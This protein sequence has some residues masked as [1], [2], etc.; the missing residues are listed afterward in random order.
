M[1]N[2]TF[3]FGPITEI[4][5]AIAGRHIVYYRIV[6]YTHY[7]NVGRYKKICPTLSVLTFTCF[8]FLARP[9]TIMYAVCTVPHNASILFIYFFF[10]IHYVYVHDVY[11]LKSVPNKRPINYLR[12][13]W[14][15][16]PLTICT[17][18]FNKCVC[19]FF[20][21]SLVHNII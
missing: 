12:G 10:I 8:R 5:V 11:E 19:V 13:P 3:K 15:R 7:P 9:K 17:R 14:W 2:Q 4:V 6:F 18:A 20:S 1:L 16:R 21:M